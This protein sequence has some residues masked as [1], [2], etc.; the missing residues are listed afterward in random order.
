MW[1]FTPIGFFSIVQK[2]GTSDLTVRTRV[3]A[4]L[5]RLRTEY[6]PQLSATVENAGTDY[7]YR[8]TVG[9][10]AFA[11]CLA[12]LA[13]DIDYANF[14]NEVARRMGHERAAVY[15]EV[16]NALLQLEHDEGA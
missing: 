13:R 15:G 12:A 11:G 14:K 2:A 9:H 6:L 1:L 10:E 5:D 4:D 8:A 16:W 7:P 3:A